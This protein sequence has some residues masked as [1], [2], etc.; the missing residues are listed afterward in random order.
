M[1]RVWPEKEK[2]ETP[3]VGGK[4]YER[5]RKDSP[6]EPSERAWPCR[7]L[8]FRFLASRTVRRQVSVILIHF[9]FGHSNPRKQIQVRLKMN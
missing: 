3:R 1:P 8:D 7:P 2:K 9:V 4:Y 6:L 5:H